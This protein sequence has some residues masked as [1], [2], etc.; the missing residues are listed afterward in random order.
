[1]SSELPDTS[2]LE[3]ALKELGRSGTSFVE[4]LRNST[5]LYIDS[6]PGLD[7]GALRAVNEIAKM[8]PSPPYS[9][10]VLRGGRIFI[11]QNA[12]FYEGDDYR[13]SLVAQIKQSKEY[14]TLAG[15]GDIEIQIIPY[16]ANIGA[17]K[18]GDH[19]DVV[20]IEESRIAS[21]GLQVTPSLLGLCAFN[22]DGTVNDQTPAS[23]S[24]CGA[25]IK[26]LNDIGDEFQVLSSTPTN[27]PS[28]RVFHIPRSV[29]EDPLLLDKYLLHI[30]DSIDGLRR[31]IYPIDKGDLF[32]QYTTKDDIK[33]LM[34]EEGISP[35]ARDQK[36]SAMQARRRE[37]YHQLLKGEG[38]PAARGMFHG[39]NT[40]LEKF[41]QQT[42]Q[43][44]LSTVRLY[45]S[46]EIIKLGEKYDKK[47]SETRV[48]NKKAI[49]YLSNHEKNLEANIERGKRLASE[50]EG[51]VA[52]EKDIEGH[53]LRCQ[54]SITK[55][56]RILQELNG[57]E[58]EVARLEEAAVKARERAT[59]T[60]ASDGNSRKTK[61]HES[62]A[63]S[64]EDRLRNS[65]SKLHEQRGQQKYASARDNK[66]HALA[67]IA[68]LDEEIGGLR[69]RSEAIR[70]EKN[71]IE[72]TIART[73][74][75]KDAIRVTE[76]ELEYAEAIIR[77]REEIRAS[78]E[79]VAQ[80]DI[81]QDLDKR[82]RGDPDKVRSGERAQQDFDQSSVTK[83]ISGGFGRK[84]TTSKMKKPN[85]TN[86]QKVR[87]VQHSSSSSF[88]G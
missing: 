3:T 49:E 15:D 19:P 48:R 39:F 70:A 40:D 85:V 50:L 67:E 52:D 78:K 27:F 20:A 41:Q 82:D 68:E 80:A 1:M 88:Q 12:R 22:A 21:P 33:T 75:A 53:I 34:R 18:E 5:P 9:A 69:C 2:G 86:V 66:V 84:E 51:I 64:T 14:K 45:S 57:L 30:T 43:D 73:Y 54:Q 28:N 13:E 8:V 72:K 7:K 10:A 56:D 76:D 44:K 25:F 65:R 61:L 74:K 42:M 63:R 79:L 59:A 29:R 87:G 62:E 26:A 11:A 58:A 35:E 16:A 17:S 6:G 47:I 24:S 36:I 81:T 55:S 38:R 4:R 31:Q 77:R 71:R 46:E 83:L 23:C 37:D 60:K 32:V